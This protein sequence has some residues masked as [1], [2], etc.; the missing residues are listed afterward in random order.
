MGNAFGNKSAQPPAQQQPGN[1]N[2]L[3]NP[4]EAQVGNVA[5]N[6]PPTSGG[7]RRRTKSGKLSPKKRSKASTTRKG[8]RKL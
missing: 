6:S 1:G 5:A 4:F 7:R 3:V 2:A 8:R